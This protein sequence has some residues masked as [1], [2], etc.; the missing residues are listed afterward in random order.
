VT[1]TRPVDLLC[2]IA[3]SA[4]GVRHAPLES[5]L[6]AE[7]WDALVALVRAQRLEPQL[8]SM[9]AGGTWPVSVDQAEDAAAAHAA[10]MATTL[11][12]DRQLLDVARQFDADEVPFVVLKGSAAAHLDYP[13]PACRAYGDVDVLVPPHKIEEAERILRAGGG[14]RAFT[15]PRPGFDRR[16]GKGSSYRMP[17]GLEVDIHRTLALGPFGLALD[18]IELAAGLTSF[19]MG[20]YELR[21]LDRSRR[22]L[23]ACYHAALGRSVPRLVP[24]VDVVMSAPRTEQEMRVAAD[25]AHRWQAD[26]VLDAAV[27]AAIRRLRWPAPPHVVRTIDEMPRSARQQRWLRGYRDERRSSALLSAAGVE[28]I[29]RWID[30]VDY[31]RASLWPGGRTPTNA[32]RRLARGAAA[33]ARG[34]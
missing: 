31:L 17:S 9:V 2:V 13:D 26:V 28:A 16:F 24:L 19:S 14:R 15:E 5:P 8:A 6:D 25:L 32:L 20:G 23:H 18:P 3:S 27:A 30:R 7:N 29:P 1:S 12:L 4:I 11:L 34:R 10:A 22:F 21:A 33:I